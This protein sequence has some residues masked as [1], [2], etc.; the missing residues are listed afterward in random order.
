MVKILIEMSY[1]KDSDYDLI[2]KQ[3]PNLVFTKDMSQK[4]DI[5]AIVS[6]PF[7]L[8]KDQLDAYRYLKWIFVLTAG[9][10]TLDLTYFKE[11]NIRLLNA[12]DVFSIQIAE[13][14]FTKILYLNRNYAIYQSQMETK[15]WKHH[16]VLHEI[17]HSTVG[18]I[19]TGSIGIEV[20]KRMKAFDTHVLGYR[21]SNKPALYFDQ[22]FT[23][24]T[25]LEF[26]IKQSDY[27]IISIPLDQSTYHLID[28]KKIKMMK[29]SALLINVARGDII[30]Q[31]ALILALQNGLIRG[32][33]LDVTSPEPL[34]KTSPLWQLPNV[35]ITPHNASASPY[36]RSRLMQVLIE[37]ISN[38]VE[39]R[40]LRNR[41]V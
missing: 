15:D 28:D 13:D 25:G 20:A 7:F 24:E 8:K 34:P 40:E 29:Q 2:T 17:A 35:C 9:Y 3:F 18:I 19:G 23:D 21:K 1:L 39:N 36:V 16:P 6:M 30:D 12:K 31:D 26:L 41:V 22:I 32:A 4:D 27:L 10:D 38:M 5:E 33:G 37:T 11:R 14:I